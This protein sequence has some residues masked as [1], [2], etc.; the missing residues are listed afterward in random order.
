MQIHT[1]YAAPN[2]Y[3]LEP[4]AFLSPGA[5]F[6]FRA[7][8]ELLGAVR[9]GV[10]KTVRWRLL[11][12]AGRSVA[13]FARAERSPAIPGTRT[14]FV[15]GFAPHDLVPGEYTLE[16][17]ASLPEHAPVVATQAVS[18]QHAPVAVTEVRLAPRGSQ[19]I[20]GSGEGR[21]ML[22]RPLALP[23]NLAAGSYAVHVTLE[24]EGV[25]AEGRTDVLVSVP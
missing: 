19:Q 11:D 3:S 17:S 8:V 2:P 6:A 9:G 12:P 5:R 22:R 21:F 23:A 14:A 7:R 25:F 15:A 16:V 18:V 20:E 1:V 13:A 4:L 10:N 24:L